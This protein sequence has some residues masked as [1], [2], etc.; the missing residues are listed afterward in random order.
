[1]PK[2]RL[3]LSLAVCFMYT[4]AI[5]AENPICLAEEPPASGRQE[6]PADAA[7]SLTAK[8]CTT[9]PPT[10][11]TTYTWVYQWWKPRGRN[12]LRWST[13][14]GARACHNWDIGGGLC[15]C[16]SG[17]SARQRFHVT[18]EALRAPAVEESRLGGRLRSRL[19]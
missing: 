9:P 18:P 7:R 16:P 4:L 2:M 1:M 3:C 10:R 13:A 14:V 8:S 15:R 12:P 11:F 5:H 19:S 17:P 6:S